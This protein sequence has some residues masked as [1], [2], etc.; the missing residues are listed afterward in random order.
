MQPMNQQMKECARTCDD[1]RTVCLETIA[2]C[3][4]KGGAHADARHV[5]LLMDCADMCATAAAL[6]HRGSEQHGQACAACAAISEAC[7]LSCEAIRND[8][9]MKACAE[10]CRR[11]AESCG[12]MA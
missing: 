4:R 9:Q 7:A 6:M 1:C 10:A 11:C 8:P 12:R 5:Q 3:L 2:Y